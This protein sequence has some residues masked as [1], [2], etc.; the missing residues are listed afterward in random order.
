MLQAA[1]TVALLSSYEKDAIHTSN[2]ILMA[3]RGN[4]LPDSCQ[5]D[6]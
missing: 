1:R 5:M 3:T 6:G 4:H 2:M